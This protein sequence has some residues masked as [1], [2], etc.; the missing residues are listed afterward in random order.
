MGDYWAPYVRYGKWKK[1][2]RWNDVD[3]DWEM[4]RLPTETWTTTRADD[5]REAGRQG[6][7]LP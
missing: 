2:Q 7:P 1:H 5:L 3:Q 6:F 4:Y